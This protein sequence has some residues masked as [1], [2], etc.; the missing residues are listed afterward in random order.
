MQWYLYSLL[1]IH[2][3]D[4]VASCILYLAS[5]VYWEWLASVSTVYNIYISNKFPFRQTSPYKLIMNSR[6]EHGSVQKESKSLMMK[7]A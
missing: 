4:K 2:I 7:N 3:W 6:V 5:R 1:G